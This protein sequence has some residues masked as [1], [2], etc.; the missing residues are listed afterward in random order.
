[1]IKSPVKGMRDILPSDMMV[2]EYVLG[3]IEQVAGRAGYQKIETPAMEHLENLQSKDGG[4]NEKLIFKVMKRGEALERAMRDNEEISDIALRYDLTVPLVRY[5]AANGNELAMPFKA[6][7]IGPVWR[8]D[9]PQKGRFRQFMQC[10]MDIIG[11][12]SVLAEIDILR[13]ALAILE[14]ICSEAGIAGLTVRVNDRRILAAAAEYAGFD[15]YE[16]VLISLDKLDKIGADGVKAELIERGCE[17]PA[18]EKLLS[19]FEGGLGVREFGERVGVD[20]EAISNL[21]AIMGAIEGVKVIFDP[22]LVRGMGYYTGPIFECSAEGLGL[23]IAG[24]GRYDKMIGK[25]SGQD[26]PACGFSIG[27]E[28]LVTILQDKG[29]VP[30]DKGMKKAI[31]VSKKVSSEKYR[32]IMARAEEMR[33]SG[34]TVS[35]MMM[36]RNLGRQ[37][38]LLER[39]GYGE[40]EKVYE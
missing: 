17:T 4:E 38:E 27:F 3:I 29:F 12:G 24:G 7:Q 32:E 19:L 13:T 6:L 10:D 11:D 21:E 37:I 30:T 9:A 40:F 23:S 31:L 26:V 34:E 1:M 5:M 22:T 36:A 39:S 8:A 25:F 33:G 2:R 20:N 16:S 14:W 35:V 18:V 15:N 28:R